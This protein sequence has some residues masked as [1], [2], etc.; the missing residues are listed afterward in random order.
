MRFAAGK[1]VLSAESGTRNG[2]QVCHMRFAA[3]QGQG[4]RQRQDPEQE[5]GQNEKQKEGQQGKGEQKAEKR[6]ASDAG[7]HI[8]Y[9]VTY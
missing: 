4:Q 7:L 3:G 9:L 2:R 6:P 8:L 5:Q 1:Q